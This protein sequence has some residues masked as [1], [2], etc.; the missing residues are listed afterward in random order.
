MLIIKTEIQ[1]SP[2]H[3]TGLFAAEDLIKGQIIWVLHKNFD[4][5]VSLEEWQKLVKPAQ[6]YLQIYMYWS[7]RKKKYVACLDNGRFMNHAEEPNTKAAY[8]G[9]LSEIPPHILE[10]TKMS[11]E[12]WELVDLSEGFTV[13]LRDIKAG[14]ELDCNYNIDFPDEGGAGSQIFLG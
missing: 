7:S 12:Q 3:G 10:K 9:T 11:K 14:E 2:I 1:K 8:F 5:V 13:T 4:A 6:D